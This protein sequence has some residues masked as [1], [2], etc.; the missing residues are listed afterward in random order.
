MK[1]SRSLIQQVM[2][3]KGSECNMQHLVH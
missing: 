1:V 2:V 3:I